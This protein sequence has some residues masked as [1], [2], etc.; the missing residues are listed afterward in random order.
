MLIKKSRDIAYSEITA[1][2]LY[3]NRRTFLTGATALAGAVL[4]GAELERVVAPSHTVLAD[5]KLNYKKG[6]Y[7]TDEKETPLK[8][9]TNYNNYYEF[10]TDKYEPAGLAKNLRT[11]PWKV[12][13]D[14]LV[15]KPQTLQIDT[16][17]DMPLEE[18]VY[19]MRCVEGWS[20]VIP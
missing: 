7:G 10:S 9:I 2:S 15:A 8:D 4:A 14:G 5:S 11:R 20:M 12:K 6:P 13:V 19:R 16:L 17:M 1:K 18:R 3:V